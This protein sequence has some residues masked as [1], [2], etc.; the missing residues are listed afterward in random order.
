M[1]L[2][3]NQ[4]PARTVTKLINESSI[5]VHRCVREED[6][7]YGP[8]GEITWVVYDEHDP[9]LCTDPFYTMWEAREYAIQ[10]VMGKE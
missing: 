7:D 6:N 10:W 2:M 1:K 5:V 3:I 4:M 9:G 8:A